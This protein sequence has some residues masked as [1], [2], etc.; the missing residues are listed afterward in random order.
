[1]YHWMVKKRLEKS[2]KALNNGRYD[3]ITRQF[4]KT[5]A[6]H[7]FSSNHPLSGLRTKYPDILLW[8]E[9]LSIL[10]P[11]L[12]FNIKKINVKGLPSK[13][14]AYIHWT[15]SLTDREGK[16]YHNKGMHIITI[17]WGKVVGLEVYCDTL[18]LNNY[19]EALVK[20]GIKEAT[21]AP[22]ES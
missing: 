14:T 19:I 11:D 20:Q 2:F 21:L 13:T 6:T 16:R 3:V 1:M 5:K 4:H 8:Y 15:D 7:W 10:M 18:Y 12:S 17:K 9:R 22:I